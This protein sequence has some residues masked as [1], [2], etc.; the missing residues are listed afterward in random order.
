MIVDEEK[1]LH[2]T[3][4]CVKKYELFKYLIQT[5]PKPTWGIDH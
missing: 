1:K 2:C 3:F 4:Q 5:G